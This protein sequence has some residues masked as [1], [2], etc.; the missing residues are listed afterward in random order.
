ME[1]SGSPQVQQRKG[2]PVGAYLTVARVL[3]TPA[4]MGVAPQLYASVWQKGQKNTRQSI[5]MALLVI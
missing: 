2:S 4:E 1:V 3:S 5:C